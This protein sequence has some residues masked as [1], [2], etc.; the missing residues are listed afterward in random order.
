VPRHRHRGTAAPRHA[1]CDGIHDVYKLLRFEAGFT[2]PGADDFLAHG[3]MMNIMVGLRM[4]N[5]YTNG[6]PGARELLETA[7]PDKIDLPL[8]TRAQSA[9][10]K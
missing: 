5:E 10:N 3:M 7:L 9:P 6:D 8:S 4:A 1:A 2:A